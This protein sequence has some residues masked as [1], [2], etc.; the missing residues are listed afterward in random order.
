MLPNFN[1]GRNLTLAEDAIELLAGGLSGGL[2]VVEADHGFSEIALHVFRMT[3]VRIRR[4]ASTFEFHVTKH[5][6]RVRSIA[7]SSSSEID[8]ILPNCS[9]GVSLIPI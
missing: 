6:S 1:I 3:L 7:T 4:P 9:P 8:M 5:P 2:S